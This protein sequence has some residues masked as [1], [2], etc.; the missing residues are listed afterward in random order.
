M[1][2]GYTSTIRHLES[3]SRKQTKRANGGMFLESMVEEM[4]YLVKDREAT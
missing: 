2:S 1:Q 3:R 4:A